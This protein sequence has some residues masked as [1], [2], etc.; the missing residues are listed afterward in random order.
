MQVKGMD[1]QHYSVTGQAQGNFN[2]V[3]AAAG[4]A[5]LLG[6]DLGSILGTGGIRT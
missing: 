5:S 3:G 6:I 4:I 1:G 2:T